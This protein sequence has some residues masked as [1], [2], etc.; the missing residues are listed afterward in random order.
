M[1]FT[2]NLLI[3]NDVVSIIITSNAQPKPEY[4][5]LLPKTLTENDV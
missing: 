1:S 3:D 4:I 2:M 5:R